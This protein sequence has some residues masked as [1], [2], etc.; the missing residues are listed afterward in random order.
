MPSVPHATLR[1]HSDRVL[2]GASFCVWLWLA[3]PASATEVWV[4]TDQAHPVTGAAS[5]HILLDAPA[6]LEAELGTGLPPDAAQATALVQKRLKR[7]GADL[8]RR[9]ASAY[10]GVTDAWRL[11]V[12]RVP[13]VVVDRHYVVYGEPD[14]AKAVARIAQH[15]KERP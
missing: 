8:Q 15:R 1:L 11:G 2:H 14:V 13:A 5:R 7:G 3:T 6:Q 9:L 4:I 10:Q 12:T